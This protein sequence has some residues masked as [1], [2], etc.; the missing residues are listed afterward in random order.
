LEQS[1]VLQGVLESNNLHK[2]TYTKG[3]AK[4]VGG[5]NIY[6]GHSLGSRVHSRPPPS[7]FRLNGMHIIK[8]KAKPSLQQ[9]RAWHKITQNAIHPSFPHDKYLHS[10]YK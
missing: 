2:G 9:I 8:V 5:K 3:V 1:D 7:V 10:I 6:G 4:G